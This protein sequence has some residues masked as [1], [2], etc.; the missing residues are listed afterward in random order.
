MLNGKLQECFEKNKVSLTNTADSHS[1]LERLKRLLKR[2]YRDAFRRVNPFSLSF[3]FDIMNTWVAL[4]LYERSGLERT[5]NHSF[6]LQKVFESSVDKILII[7]GAAA[8]GKTCLMRRIAFD[9]ANN[10]DTDEHLSSHYDI[11]Y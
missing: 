5:E 10:D 2:I 3:L 8:T 11:S 1:V 4:G 6:L 7:E 9:W